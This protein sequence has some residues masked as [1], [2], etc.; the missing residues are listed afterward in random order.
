MANLAEFLP[1]PDRVRVI[2]K[3]LGKLFATSLL[4]YSFQISRVDPQT[5]ISNDPGGD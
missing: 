1:M 2:P 3:R 5:R 4:G